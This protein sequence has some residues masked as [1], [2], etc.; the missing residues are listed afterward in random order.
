MLALIKDLS[1]I[2]PNIR[3][4]NIPLPTAR[5]ENAIETNVSWNY[6]KESNTLKAEEPLRWTALKRLKT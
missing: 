2:I 3:L 6:K 4:E 5:N 1:G